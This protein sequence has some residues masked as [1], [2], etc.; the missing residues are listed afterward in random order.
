MFSELFKFAKGKAKETN[1]SLD[2]SDLSVFLVIF[3]DYWYCFLSVLI[4]F[5]SIELIYLLL[6]VWISEGKGNWGCLFEFF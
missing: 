6:S 5:S 4:F 1:E 3:K 2:Q